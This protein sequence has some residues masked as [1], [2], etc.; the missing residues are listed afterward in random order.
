MAEEKS[1]FYSEMQQEAHIRRLAALGELVAEVAHETNNLMLGV[2]G[3]VELE[4]SR[5]GAEA[6]SGNLKHILSCAKGVKELNRK[7]LSFSKFSCDEMHGD[8]KEALSSAVDLMS[9]S[10]KGVEIILKDVGALPP[11]FLSTS[12]LR[13]IIANLVKNA[14]EAATLSDNPKVVVKAETL[15]GEGVVVSVWNSGNPI[16]ENV[17]SR[18]FEPFFSTKKGDRGS[19]LGLSISYRLAAQGGGSLSALNPPEG[20]ALF[21]LTLP[22]F[23][24]DE[25]GLEDSRACE[26]SAPKLSGY[27]VLVV[28][29]DNMARDVLRL[30]V[31]EMGGAEVKT[32]SS[33]EEAMAELKADNYDA[34]VLDLRMPGITGQDIFRSLSSQI[35]R[36][37][38]FVTGDTVEAATRKFILDSHQPTLF[39]P[40][41]WRELLNA[42]DR[43]ATA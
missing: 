10:H 7:L 34:V 43:V 33:G 28:D 19:G 1:P 17:L 39:K 31:S 12:D 37:V 11:A 9:I 13:L 29:D 35:K 41:D 18:L 15:P 2:L 40:I 14:I 3:Y 6:Y 5:Q 38:V 24:A 8:I 23:R 27:R 32:C 42:V 26:Q 20:G 16:A 30:M 36:R 22:T 25:A 4:M 21:K